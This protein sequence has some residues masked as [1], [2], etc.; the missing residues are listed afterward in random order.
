MPENRVVN[1]KDFFEYCQGF[2]FDIERLEKQIE[3]TRRLLELQGVSYDEK[4]S[5]GSSA[6]RL[7][8]DLVALLD[9]MEELRDLQG[10]YI[11]Q[12]R[13]MEYVIRHI[14]NPWQRQ[15]VSLR[16]VSGLSYS[17]IGE[18]MGYTKNGAKALVDRCFIDMD[19]WLPSV[20]QKYS[21]N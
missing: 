2:D 11:D 1:P 3:K 15:A 20:L 10:A 8:D 6:N 12:Q 13:K 9:Y 17:E 14:R 19:T 21:S 7:V 18:R 16:Y 5:T 4:V